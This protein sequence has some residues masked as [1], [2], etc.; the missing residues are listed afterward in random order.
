MGELGVPY[1]LVF[2]D[3]RSPD[4]GW[5]LLRGLHDQDPH[6]HI[7]RLSRNFGQH[8]AIT[9]GLAE[10]AGAW[11]VVMDCD[12]QDRPEDIPRLYVEAK[13]GADVVV[14]RRTRPDQALHR[15]MASKANNR[16]RRLLLRADLED[17]RPNLSMISRQVAAEFLRIEDT[18]RSYQLVLQWLGFN[19]V[20]IDVERAERDAG[21]SSYTPGALIR[22]AVD[23]LFFEPAALLPWI[24]Y[25]G[26]AVLVGG[27]A[28]VVFFTVSYLVEGS[29]PG[30]TALGAIVLTT[31][32]FV[33]MCTGVSALY[34]GKVF[35]Q[36]K[37]RPLYVI[38]QR[39]SADA[40]VSA[41]PDPHLSEV[42][43]AGT[44]DRE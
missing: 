26:L 15:R 11:I 1:E 22:L 10:A 18:H 28:L 4:D 3:D 34:V 44:T 40:E 7:V 12:L 42:V 43:S 17:G 20:S 23:G 30:W 21:E 31:G 39:L 14:T 29:A 38:D 37:G 9:A 24:V 13:R 16:A 8:A 19:Q 32:G 36:V 25:T 41:L 35:E 5:D 2:V 27:I 6:V 33:I